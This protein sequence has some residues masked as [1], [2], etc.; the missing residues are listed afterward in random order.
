M[1]LRLSVPRE[2]MLDRRSLLHSFDEPQGDTS[3][4][5]SFGRFRRMAADMLVSSNRAYDLDQEDP[6]IRTLYGDHIGGQSML[7]ARRLVETGVPVVQVNA[8]AGDLAGGGGD[9]WDTHRDH[10]SKMKKRLL[11][12]FD[13][14]FSA[15][16]TDLDQ[17]GLLDET[18]VAVITD[19][20]RTPK[21]NGN[22]GR[23][24]HPGVYSQVL[25][26]GG[27]RGGQVY[28]SSDRDGNRPATKAC[29]PSDFHATVYTALGIDPHVTIKDQMGRPFEVCH[30]SALPL[31]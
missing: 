20:G 25:A 29:S 30:G 5:A 2:R 8:G 11:P 21:I 3:D 31:F 17:R 9:N 7:L 24:H 28:G 6:R 23:D 18:L 15:L 26:G 12:V 27:I 13:R 16:L 19:F 14:A 4:Y 1:D 10:F 22:G